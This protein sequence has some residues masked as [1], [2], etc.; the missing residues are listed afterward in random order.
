[1]LGYIGAENVIAYWVTDDGKAFT[2]SVVMSSP[3]TVEPIY[4]LIFPLETLPLVIFAL[5]GTLVLVV[6]IA[7]KFMS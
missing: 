4:V 7:R 6:I 5:S 3:E 1:M 2:N